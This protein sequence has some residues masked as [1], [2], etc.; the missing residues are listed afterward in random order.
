MQLKRSRWISY[1]AK[2]ILFLCND[3]TSKNRKVN[4]QEDSHKM[5]EVGGNRFSHGN[6]RYFRYFK[7]CI[8][9]IMRMT[10]SKNNTCFPMCWILFMMLII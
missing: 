8:I 9:N 6:V 3:F 7:N 4:A 1:L 2:R 5:P 10:Y